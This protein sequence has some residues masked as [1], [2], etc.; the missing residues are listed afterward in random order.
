MT[1]Q[2]I[3]E[4]VSEVL[5]EFAP[6]FSEPRGRW[7]FRGHAKEKYTL[8]PAVGRAHR[9]PSKRQKYEKSL[10]DMFCRE[11]TIHVE[12]RP[13]SEWEWLALAQHHGLPTRLL[14]WTD[15]P[16][17]ALYFAVR[18]HDFENGKVFA[19]HMPRKASTTTLSASPFRITRAVKYRPAIVTPRIRAQEAVFVACPEGKQLSLRDCRERTIP[20]RTK[21]EVRY[22]LYRL[23]VHDSTLFPDLDGLARRLAWQHSIGPPSAWRTA[24]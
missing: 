19:L 24:S 21:A 8:T 15:N 11:A 17:V 5:T 13:E 20:V 12:P 22:A 2:N 7:I 18:K 10:F 14:D 3:W 1:H 4:T 9:T 16:L 6:C 23:G